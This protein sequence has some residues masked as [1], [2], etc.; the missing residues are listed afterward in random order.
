MSGVGVL[1]ERRRGMNP[2][3]EV[4]STRHAAARG[5]SSRS[6]GDADVWDPSRKAKGVGKALQRNATRGIVW[7]QATLPLKE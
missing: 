4:T 1:V 7:P 6:I 5:G 3:K 2:P